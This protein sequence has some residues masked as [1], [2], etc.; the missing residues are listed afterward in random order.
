MFAKFCLRFW[1]LKKRNVLPGLTFSNE[2]ISKIYNILEPGGLIRISVP[3]IEKLFYLYQ[4]QKKLDVIKNAIMGGQSYLNDFHKSIYDFNELKSIL[5]KNNY[6]DI[7]IWETENV[8]GESI[9]DWSDGF[10]KFDGKKYKISLNL[11][12]SK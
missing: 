12:G 10:Y 3:D 6:K 5:E 9:G 4:K 7:K 2:L 8:F 11:V 1:Y